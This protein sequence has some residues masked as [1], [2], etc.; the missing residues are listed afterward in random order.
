MILPCLSLE[1]NSAA[2]ADFS[3]SGH[4]FRVVVLLFGIIPATIFERQ[5]W[6]T[7]PTISFWQSSHIPMQDFRKKG[8]GLLQYSHSRIFEHVGFVVAEDESF[9][10]FGSFGCLGLECGPFV[11]EV[12]FMGLV[13]EKSICRCNLNVRGKCSIFEA[14]LCACVAE[15][16][17]LAYISF[18]E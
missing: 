4:F 18:K 9:C 5:T 13:N 2:F 10:I 14:S 17:F 1:S 8:Q 3:H 12:N 15:I 7:Y 11:F 6:H 16:A